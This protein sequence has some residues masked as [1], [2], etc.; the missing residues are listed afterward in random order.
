[1]RVQVAPALIALLLPLTASACDSGPAVPDG[2]AP[3]VTKASDDELAE[4]A[5]GIGDDDA[6]A[7]ARVAGAPGIVRT[8]DGATLLTWSESGTEGEWSASAWIAFS[9]DGEI[10]GS[11]SSR[12]FNPASPVAY[13]GGF[14]A[15][16]PLDLDLPSPLLISESGKV[17]TP[18]APLARP[19]PARPGDLVLGGLGGDAFRPSDGTLAP[20]PEAEKGI[21][22]SLMPTALD[23]SGA[24]T[25]LSGTVRRPV[26][27]HSADGGATWERKEIELPPG[28][29]IVADDLFAGQHRTLLPLQDSKSQV[30][31]WITRSTGDAAWTVTSFDPVIEDAQVLGLVGERVLVAPFD[32][33]AGMLISL[34]DTDDRIEVD[35]KELRASGGKVYSM[36]PKVTESADGKTWTDVPLQ[37]PKD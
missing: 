26:L 33:S 25:V 32:D 30:A 2:A 22:G 20:L 17:G 18:P 35:R 6:L 3:W 9:P 7:L 27:N 19:R 15:A 11:R 31:G 5:D 28:L 29:T 10:T 14:L 36:S 13:D 8:P 1:M 37:F 21:E 12:Q 16:G 23:G 4:V 34:D 24:L